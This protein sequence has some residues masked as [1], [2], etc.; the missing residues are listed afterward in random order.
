MSA[1]AADA[2]RAAAADPRDGQPAGRSPR[3]R[4]DDRGRPSD[5]PAPRRSDVRTR[6]RAPTNQPARAAAPVEPGVRTGAAAAGRPGPSGGRRPTTRAP[7]WSTSASRWTCTTGSAASSARPNSTI[8][9]LRRPSLTELVIALLEEGPQT[10][11]EVAE[12]IRRKRAAEHG[13]EGVK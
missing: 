8:R 2:V 9:R 7:G 3:R 4:A 11:D 10:A 12:L 1:S 5:A 13:A 6:G